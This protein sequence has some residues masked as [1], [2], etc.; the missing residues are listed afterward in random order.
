MH[1]E[2][3]NFPLSLY[4][5][6]YFLG[7]RI[8]NFVRIKSGQVGVFESLLWGRKLV[9]VIL[10][11]NYEMLK[12]TKATV[13]RRDLKMVVNVVSSKR[14]KVNVRCTLSLFS[15]FIGQSM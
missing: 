2:K 4:L 7:S 3:A 1:Q 9:S 14:W 6:R 15:S 11:P 5:V 13:T 12:A 10:I 8:S